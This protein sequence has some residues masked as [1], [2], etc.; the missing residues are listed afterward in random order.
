MH[1]VANI[2][3]WLGFAIF[4]VIALYVD[5]VVLEKRHAGPHTSIKSA[6]FWS[7]VWIICALLFN[8]FLWLDLYFTASITIA[9]QKSLE[10]FAG[11]LIEK[12]LSVDNL[13]AFYVV[14]H[15]FHIPHAYQHRIFAIGIWSAI[16]LRLILILLGVWLIS[17]FGWVL[18]LMGTFLFFTGLKMFFAEEKAKD[19]AETLTI[20]IVNKFLRVS[21]EITSQHFF[22][23]KNN[24]L[25]MTPLFLALIFI[26]LSDLVFALDSIPAIFAITMDP[27]IVWTSNIFAIL[28]LRALY[29]LLAGM[30]YRFHMLKHGV[31][32]ILVFV[33][34][35]M[36]LEP[37]LHISVLWSLVMILSIL[38]IFTGLSLRQKDDQCTP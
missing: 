9:N 15:Q 37:W 2:W 25:Y 32:L 22:M 28:G 6:L 31:A 17:N 36:L 12:S 3:M 34:S 24:L 26:E 19:L 4:L 1:N 38:L 5:T 16:V 10:F 33:G 27:Y 21:H 7:M 29:F 35:K 18:Y 20:K 14:F 13:F 8:G 30:A 11:Y 23:R